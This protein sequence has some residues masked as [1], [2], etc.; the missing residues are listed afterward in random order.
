[1][2]EYLD[3]T[4]GGFYAWRERRPSRTQTENE[5]LTEQVRDVFNA[6]R[7]IYG[8][9]RVAAQLRQQGLSIGRRRVAK[10]MRQAN[11][12]GRSARIYRRRKVG[13]KQFFTA[14][15]N[16]ERQVCLERINQVW[17]GDVT[18]LKVNQ[19]WRYLAVVMDK[20]SRK[21]LGWDLSAHR[22]TDLTVSAY[23]KATQTR[24]P[25]AGLVFHTDRGIEYSGFA[26]KEAL[27]KHGV[28]RSVN[29]PRRMNDNAHMES[30]FHL[31][32]SEDLYAKRFESDAQLRQTLRSYIK[33]Y[34]Q[35][36]LHSSLG[37]LS[38]NNFEA[39]QS[40]Q[41]TVN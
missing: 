24:K 7:C 14:T 6:S 37:Y 30:F 26:H 40:N 22:D 29:R 31:L 33:F 17:V 4:R 11:I 1:M 23:R 16:V 41:S 5:G 21:I 13:M 9:P 3:V 39:L 10:L 28:I 25:P 8:A 12:Q 27:D 38:P 19:Q 34:N 32:K 20:Y 36:R 15:K 18:Y 35:Q 2:C